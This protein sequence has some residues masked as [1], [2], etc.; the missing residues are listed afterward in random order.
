M[1]AVL[2]LVAMLAGP[3]VA[4]TPQPWLI[5]DRISAI[6]GQRV[7][8]AKYNSLDAA[9]VI[10][11]VNGTAVVGLM[12]DRY[13]T[14]SQSTLALMRFGNHH[15]VNRVWLV[16]RGQIML[17]GDDAKEILQKALAV[18]YFHIRV[19]GTEVSVPMAVMKDHQISLRASCGL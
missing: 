17:D 4:V 3:A 9:F 1:R 16:W 7:F 18:E 5:D 12:S 6:D 11:C 8:R 19:A 10:N 13:S 14:L 2:I 15:P